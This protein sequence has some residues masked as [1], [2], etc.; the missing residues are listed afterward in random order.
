MA[1]RIERDLTGQKF[2][3]WTVLYEGEPLMRG[4][5][6]VIHKWV[7]Q[8]DCGK[9]KSVSER[10]LLDGR[11]TSCGC[12]HSEIMKDVSK[13]ANSTHGMSN[14]R[15]YRTWRHMLNRC[16]N[17]NDIRYDIYGAR[18]VV[19][20]DAWQKF[21]N[22]ATWAMDNGYSDSLTIDRIDVNGNYEPENCQWVDNKTQANN[23]RSCRLY[24][25]DGETHNIAEWCRI[26]NKPYKL[27]WK[28]LNKGLN[29]QTALSK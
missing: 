7:C 2:G 11:S 20:C 29:I 17:K 13:K 27:V 28:R 5:N 8:C 18:G 4:D 9:I 22:F 21:E 1:R 23:R 26:Y 25:I 15:L 12:Y 24:E 10:S 6:R 3:R 14:T 16:Y 19:V